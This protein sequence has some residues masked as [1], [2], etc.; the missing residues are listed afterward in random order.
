MTQATYKPAMNYWAPSIALVCCY[1]TVCFAEVQDLASHSIDPEVQSCLERS[2]PRIS[3]KENISLHVSDDK[4]MVSEMRAELYWKRFDNDLSKAVIRFTDPPAKSRI[5]LLLEQSD[6]AEAEPEM[7]IYLPEL[8]ST[9]RI[10]G[11]ALNLK[12]AVGLSICGELS[13]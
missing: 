2:A 12:K 3:L 8:R 13:G 10:V 4:G 5:A 7:T 9:R 6:D 11:T 1:A